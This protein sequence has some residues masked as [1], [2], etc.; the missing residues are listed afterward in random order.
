MLILQVFLNVV[1]IDLWL[2]LLLFSTF[3]LQSVLYRQFV[4]CTNLC[5]CISRHFLSAYYHAMLSCSF[6]C[7]PCSFYCIIF[8][9]IN[10]DDDDDDDVTK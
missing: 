4:K 10:D 1:C 9:Q 8:E 6:Y 2:C 5:S 7:Y 3:L